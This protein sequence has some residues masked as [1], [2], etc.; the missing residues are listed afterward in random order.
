MTKIISNRRFARE[1]QWT[2]TACVELV[3]IHG[4]VE[5]HVVLHICFRAL[6]GNL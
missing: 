6:D 1:E 2:T 4:Y 5:K 3:R